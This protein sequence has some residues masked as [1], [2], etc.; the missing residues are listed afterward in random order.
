[1]GVC[2][3]EEEKED[4][5]GEWNSRVAR[6]PTLVCHFVRQSSYSRAQTHVEYLRKREY[7][8]THTRSLKTHIFSLLSASKKYPDSSCHNL[9]RFQYLSKAIAL[10]SLTSLIFCAT[11][12]TLWLFPWQ[13]QL[14]VC[15]CVLQ[16]GSDGSSGSLMITNDIKWPWS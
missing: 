1:M 10:H 7:I 9:I 5:E 11:L 3:K 14:P 6:T 12:Q 16:G 15:L 4:R 13:Q 8:Y 2:S